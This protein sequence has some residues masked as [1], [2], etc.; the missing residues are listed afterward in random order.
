M[1]ALVEGPVVAAAQRHLEGFVDAVENRH[2]PAPAAPGFLRTL[3][4][5]PLREGLRMAP[6]T[7]IRE[8]EAAHLAAAKRP[9]G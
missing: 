8:I 9:S 2:K 3:S 6:A 1:Q 4:A 5:R 7:R